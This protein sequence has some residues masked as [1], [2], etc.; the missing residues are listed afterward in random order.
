MRTRND[1]TTMARIA[2]PG[3][4]PEA[5]GRAL[6]SHLLRHA[7]GHYAALGRDRIGLGVDTDNSSGALAPYERHG[8]KLDLAVD[9]WELVLPVTGTPG[10]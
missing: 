9:T 3:V 6:G 1:R 10:K 7:F 4:L 2:N 5:R 8:M